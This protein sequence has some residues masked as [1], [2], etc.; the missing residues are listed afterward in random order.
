MNQNVLTKQ[1]VFNALLNDGVEQETISK[2]IDYHSRNP[3]LFEMF[4]FYAM[5]V[6][7]K[8]KKIGAM[9][10][11][12]RIRW[13]AEVEGCGDFKINN[14]VAPYFARIFEIKYPEHEGIFEKRSTPGVKEIK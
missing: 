6:A 1:K 8:K 3:K 7:D 13:D 11:V 10:I 14:N 5:R 12:N 2:V 4:E 9:A